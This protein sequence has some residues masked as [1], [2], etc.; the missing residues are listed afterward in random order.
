MVKKNLSVRNLSIVLFLVIAVLA[1]VNYF[2]I[3]TFKLDQDKDSAV[4]DASGRNRML[5]QKIAFL[6]GGIINGRENWKEELSKTLAL[7]DNSLE[8][9]KS[10]GVAPGIADGAILPAAPSEF[11]PKIELVESLWR[12]YNAHAQVILNQPVHIPDQENKMILNPEVGEAIAFLE[13]NAGNLLIRCND[14]VKAFV[15]LSHEKQALLDWVLLILLLVNVAL[16]GLA[17][18]MV[19]KFILKPIQNISQAARGVASGNLELSLHDH[20]DADFQSISKSINK[21]GSN[22]NQSALFAENIGNGQF[23]FDLENTEENNRLFS[24]LESMREK[25]KLVAET[26]RQQNWA[27]EGLAG[28]SELVRVNQSET[29]D[30]YSKILAFII[31]YVGLNQGGIFIV[32]SD[33]EENEYLDLKASYA[34]NRE[35][36]S[37]KRLEK[38]EGLVGQCWLERDKILMT[39]VPKDYVRIG[40][41]LGTARPTCVLIVPLILQDQVYGIAEFASFHKLE[42]H[43]I[44]L[45]ERFAETL[46]STISVVKV[47]DHTNRLLAESQ[48]QAEKLKQQEEELRQNAEEMQ[49]TQEELNRRIQYLEEQLQTQMADDPTDIAIV[50]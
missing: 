22:I 36:Y 49:A 18:F 33:Q 20:F 2:V 1:S 12:E 13:Q 38:G 42:D 25:L 47:N 29:T 16:V 19:R 3:K 28:L 23:E 35:K 10:G 27:S 43:E 17:F 6:S 34:F 50:S 31:N 39:K 32:E 46:A 14:L 30:F 37:S 45:I 44:E 4:V 15:A 9:L 11:H 26:D 7:F 48:T 41:G 40:S 5:S 24:A 21:L 8:A